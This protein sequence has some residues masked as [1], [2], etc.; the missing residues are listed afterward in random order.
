MGKPVIVAGEAWI[1]GKGFSF[2]ASS[3]DDYRQLLEC[4]PMGGNLEPQKRG[5]ALKYAFHFF[6]RRM[7]PLPFVKQLTRTTFTL[8]GKDLS[9]FKPGATPGLDVICDG[10]LSNIQ[11]IY[12]AECKDDS[13]E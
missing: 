8:K 1:R 5:L 13:Y 11:F 6:F 12:P 3:P 9:E 4:L 7:I 10:I 2:D